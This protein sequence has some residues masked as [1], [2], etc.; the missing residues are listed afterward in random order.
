[1]QRSGAPAQRNNMAAA[2]FILVSE[3]HLG[4]QGKLKS[5]LVYLLTF[6]HTVHTYI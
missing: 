5:L 3:N 4:F 1:M 2:D 6:T